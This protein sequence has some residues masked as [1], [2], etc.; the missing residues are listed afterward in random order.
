M[1]RQGIGPQSRPQPQPAPRTGLR[2]GPRINRGACACV[3][4][5]AGWMPVVCCS[6]GIV[7]AIL[8]GLGLGTAYF[9]IGKYVLW[10]FGWTPTL[11]AGSAILILG[12][13]YLL[14]RPVFRRYGAEVA[15]PIFWRTV[16][17]STLG[18][19]VTFMLW[20]QVIIPGMYAAGLPMGAL[21]RR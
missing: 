8:T 16:G 6:I 10:G 2:E 13:S 21:F 11:A 3:G 19:G 9:A 5:L 4:A 14:V 12:A 20:M 1:V 18:A 17:Y 7:P 15:K